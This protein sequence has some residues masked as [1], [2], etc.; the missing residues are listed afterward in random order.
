MNENNIQNN[1]Q[2]SIK[3]PIDVMLEMVKNE[4]EEHVMKSMEANSIHPT[5]MV[6]ILK[7][8]ALDIYDL[9]DKQL[10][11][12]YVELQKSAIENDNQEG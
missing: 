10:A 6:Y 12:C 9:K 5:F 7:S 2:V 4:I 3:T 8:I 11:E 1:N